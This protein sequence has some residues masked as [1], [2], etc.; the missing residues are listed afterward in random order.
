MD[1][2]D[3]LPRK[4]KL[5]LEYDGTAYRGW[6]VQAE[7]A[8]IQGVL[9]EK[10]E[11]ITGTPV[12]VTGAGRTDSG[13]HALAQVASFETRSEIA[14]EQ[15]V[16]ALNALLPPDIAAQEAE[17]VG[18][19]F[20]A[21]RSARGKI[22]HYQIWNAER[23]SAFHGRYAWRLRR[24]LQQGAMRAAAAHLL[25]EHDFSAFRA[26]DCPAKHPVRTVRRIEITEL[27]A[28]LVR[29]EI[30][31]TA[32]LKHMV[33]NIVGT[34]VEVGKGKRTPDDVARV[35]AGRDRTQAGPTAPAHGLFLVR[36]H[37]PPAG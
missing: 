35:L 23:R 33:R 37:Y 27:Q 6:Q 17:L 7:G 25:G 15:L 31:A 1:E 30:E 20:D 3:V 26:A 24:P 16:R 22:Y 11:V 5:T 19:D 28:P 9:E 14:P 4:L 36:V 8:T 32:F 10:L 29:I 2:P 13:V 34:L 21:R 12:R 18:P